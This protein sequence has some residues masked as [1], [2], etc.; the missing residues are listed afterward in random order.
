[1]LCFTKA[2]IAGLDFIIANSAKYDIDEN[3]LSLEIQQLGLPTENCD[4]LLKSYK[5]GMPLS[6]FCSVLRK[7]PHIPHAS[8]Y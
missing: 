3:T 1:M 2:A 4:A 6:C 5:D 7:Q 8:L